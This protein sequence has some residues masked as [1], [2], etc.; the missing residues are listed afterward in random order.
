MWSL[1]ANQDGDVEAFL[2]ALDHP[3]KPAIEEVRLIIKGAREGITEHIK[4]NA[5]LYAIP[6]TYGII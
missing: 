4:W 2:A 5:S 1:K 6:A 3:L